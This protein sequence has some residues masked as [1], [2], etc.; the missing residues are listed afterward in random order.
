[1]Y[2]CIYYTH[3]NRENHIYSLIYIKTFAY[4]N[5]NITFSLSERNFY[6]R[7]RLLHQS[8]S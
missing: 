8:K 6:Y 2:V 3:R 1:M 4:M 5:F 7:A